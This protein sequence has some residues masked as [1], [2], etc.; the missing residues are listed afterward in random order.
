MNKVNREI[1]EKYNLL[2]SQKH[3]LPKEVYLI[4]LKNIQKELRVLVKNDINNE[5]GQ[6]N[7]LNNL[8]S[9]V[10]PKSI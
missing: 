10:K 7:I 9:I 1:I 5:I 8:L 4:R 3:Q 2:K 6:E